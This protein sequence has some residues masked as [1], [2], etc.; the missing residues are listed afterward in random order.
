[1][2]KTRAEWLIP[3]KDA[4]NQRVARIKEMLVDTPYITLQELGDEFGVTRE[5]MRQIL[6]KNSIKKPKTNSAL[7]PLYCDKGHERLAIR[8]NKKRCFICKPL[9]ST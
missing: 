6:N 5:R 3:Y 7:R 4:N 1:M 9:P 8:R 2:S